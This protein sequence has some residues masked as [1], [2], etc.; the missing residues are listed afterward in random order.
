MILYLGPKEQL[1]HV[2]NL[3]KDYEVVHCTSEEEID[4]KLPIADVILDA[5]L[6]FSFKAERL[7]K[8]QSLRLFVAASTG[9]N[10]ID[11]EYLTVKGIPLFN[12][13]GRPEIRDITAAAEMSWLLLMAVARQLRPAIAHVMEG[14]WDRSLFPGLM[15]KGRTVGLVGCGRIGTWM[16][17]YATAFGMTTFGYDPYIDEWPENITRC[18]S[19]EELFNCDLSFLCIH[20]PLNEKTK[21]LIMWKHFEMMRP[22]TILV[23]TSRGDIVDEDALVQALE[24]GIIAG[25]GVDVITSEP[26]I[27]QSNLYQYAQNHPEVVITPHIGG[28]SPDALSFVLK[29][30]CERII[31]YVTTS[32]THSK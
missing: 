15:L 16:S 7:K 22:G 2:S 6:K 19:L 11:Q 21:G 20:V 25:V 12:L 24:N 32:C 3:L 8:A 17:R 5:S 14:Q 31:S 1:N 29:F 23:N 10:H 26:N 27:S 30:C 18:N 9:C 28:C 4:Q 13:L